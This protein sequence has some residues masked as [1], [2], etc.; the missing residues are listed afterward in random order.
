MPAREA[1]QESDLVV[2]VA[3]LVAVF[4][5]LYVSLFALTGGWALGLISGA[6]ELVVAWRVTPP[7]RARIL[8][9]ITAVIGTITVVWA[10]VEIFLD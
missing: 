8:R 2:L 10:V 6:V 4:G 3:G 9:P 5:L 1:H 7:V